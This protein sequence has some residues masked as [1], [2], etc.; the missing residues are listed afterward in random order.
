VNNTLV[1]T[2]GIQNQNSSTGIIASN[3][4]VT[5]AS[6]FGGITQQT[7]YTGA[8]NAAWFWDPAQRNYRLKPAATALVGAGTFLDT[9]CRVDILG[10]TRPNPPSIGA[11]EVYQSADE[12][13]AAVG[14]RPVAPR[15]AGAGG[16][17]TVASTASGRQITVRVSR[18][19]ALAD[20]AIFDAAGRHVFTLHYGPLGPGEQ[21][22]TWTGTDHEQ[23][24]MARSSYVA[25]L[26]T[27]ESTV[28]C[29]FGW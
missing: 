11:Y 1:S 21:V 7:N 12:V 6:I 25:R 27:T 3:N 15:R 16:V 9:L 22:F 20:L 8:Y 5:G 4:V 17:L 24:R 10:K 13:P 2:Q 14:R 23:R 29:R 28:V 26:R 18:E 19:L